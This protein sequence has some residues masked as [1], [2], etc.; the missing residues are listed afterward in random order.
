LRLW[1]GVLR[2]VPDARLMLMAPPGRHREGLLVRL[3]AEGVDRDRVAFVAYRPRS[4]YLRSYHDIDVGLDTFPYNG[5]TT[6]LDSL[7]MGVP[8]VS[9]VGATC[10]GRGGLSQLHNVGLAELAADSDQAFVD[11][12]VALARDM[13]RLERLRRDLRGR[14]ERSPLMAASAFTRDLEAVY[15]R[16]WG[17]YCVSSRDDRAI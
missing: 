11:A 10:V 16:T 15:R 3:A 7:W 8:V 12:A 2:A 1:G 14:L 13:P 5:H 6:S 4:D 17:E 9:R